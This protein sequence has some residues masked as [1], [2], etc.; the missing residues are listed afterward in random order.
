MP[1]GHDGERWKDRRVL[2]AML[3]LAIATFPI[4]CS[5]GAAIAVRG[6]VA[7]P[8]TILGFALW[9]LGTLA[10]CTVVFLASER[11]ARR[12]VPLAVLLKMGM[13]FPGRAPRRLAVARRAGS[14]RD[15]HRRVEEARTR[16]L[17]DEPTVAA[18]RIVTL[19]ATLSAHDR[20]TRGHAE[21]VR[22]LTDMIAEELHLPAVHCDR[23][24]WSS[25]L[26]DIGK[27][28]VHPETLNKSSTL[29]SEEWAIL[30]RHPL[31]GARL[32]API[33]GWLG[34]WASTIAEHHERFDGRGYPYG[35]A[36][37]QIS[38]GGRIVAV[39]DSFDV[40]TSARS[41]KKPIAPEKA[42]QE[43]AACAGTQFDPEVVRA[44][45]AVSVW[46]LRLAAPLSWLASMSSAKVVGAAARVGTLSGHSVI[47]GVAAAVGVLGLSAATPLASSSV[48]PRAFGTA[49]PASAAV[50][51]PGSAGG[52]PG[53]PSSPGRGAPAHSTTTATAGN[54]RGAT[55][56]TT[57]KGTG[58]G[59]PGTTT[60]TTS[61][62]TGTT[63]TVATT[64]T[65]VA[66]TTTTAT[67][68]P[69]A[70]A[71]PP[72]GLSAV[73]QCQLV[74]IGPEVS[75]SWTPSPSPSVTSY[76]VLRKNGSGGGG[77][78]Q[79]IANVAA[80]TTSYADTSVGGL[81][82]TY[83]YKIQANA[84]GGNATSAIATATTPGL[85]L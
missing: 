45:L 7:P 4:G 16:G 15:L 36:G 1:A 69:P 48:T 32:T 9:W 46:R 54:G 82:T 23:L 39:A 3:G 58:G 30:R 43:L 12:V 63:T 71:A 10:L 70:P 61:K 14:V 44:F 67:T 80:G 35:I 50:A 40:M 73:G 83:T 33:A 24:R 85:C 74:L 84:P 26:H 25:L 17:A 75:L 27:L 72:S 18:E 2:A 66:T 56:T 5:V 19:A 37:R 22:A 76:T 81:G 21:R 34:D 31:E 8:A 11:I 41:Y 65:T 79:T 42:R 60:S 49:S 47:A 6:F 53:A 57:N 68:P 78:F 51:T 29:S 38:L 52:L 64:T 77:S 28:T 62:G 55:T 13:A 20:T 59:A